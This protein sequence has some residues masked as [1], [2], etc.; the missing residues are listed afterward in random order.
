MKLKVL[1]VLALFAQV[2][3]SMAS[4]KLGGRMGGEECAPGS[5][6]ICTSKTNSLK[7]GQFNVN[8]NANAMYR[9]PGSDGNKTLTQVNFK[10]DLEDYAN[11]FNPEAKLPVLARV[12]LCRN[13]WGCQFETQSVSFELN[14]VPN[15]RKLIGVLNYQFSQ[16]WPNGEEIW[17]SSL[18]L[19]FPGRGES[20]R[21]NY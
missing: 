14:R 7:V 11:Y 17:V 4:D 10:V 6:R 8:V 15:Q 12:V 9:D 2:S 20:F 5:L 18:E 1:F 16:D 19:L 3:L 21:F 13:I